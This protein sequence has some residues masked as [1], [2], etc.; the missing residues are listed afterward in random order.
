[1]FPGGAR[2]RRCQE[3]V[4][5]TSGRITGEGD[6]N[7]RV[8]I[9]GDEGGRGEEEEVCEG[10]CEG[11]QDPKGDHGGRY[12]QECTDSCRSGVYTIPSGV[13][14]DRLRKVEEEDL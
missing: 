1:M 12:R 4:G 10:Q 7:V 5:R 13:G 6:P 3:V 11:D 2:N 14:P 8:S 9:R